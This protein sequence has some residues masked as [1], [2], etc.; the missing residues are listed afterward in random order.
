MKKFFVALV[1]FGILLCGANVLFAEGDNMTTADFAKQLIGELGIANQL[2]PNLASLSA[3][4][5]YDAM[6]NLLASRGIAG[7][8]GIEPTAD[9]T[10]GFFADINFFGILSPST[11][12]F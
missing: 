2:P 12:C 9:V 7:F 11:G 8:E 1:C 10:R 4:D 5:A 6:A 3:Q